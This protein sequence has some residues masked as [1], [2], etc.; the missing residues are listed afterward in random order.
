MILIWR[1]VVATVRKGNARM[2][3]KFFSTAGVVLWV[4]AALGCTGQADAPLSPTATSPIT[5]AAADGST[6]KV[7][8]PQLVSPTGGGRTDTTTPQFVLNNASAR[9]TNSPSIR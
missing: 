9:F 5:D 3:R 2:V 8:A 7:S 6:L 1:S 4:V